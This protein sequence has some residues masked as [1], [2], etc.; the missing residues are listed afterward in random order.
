VVYRAQNWFERKKAFH[1][2]NKP[3]KLVTGKAILREGP[4]GFLDENVH[5]AIE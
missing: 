2:L 4:K 1:V 3:K 5:L